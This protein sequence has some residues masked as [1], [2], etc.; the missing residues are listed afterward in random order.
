MTLNHSRLFLPAILRP[1]LDP[2]FFDLYLNC[3]EERMKQEVVI[4]PF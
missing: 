1:G 4:V 3:V 2:R